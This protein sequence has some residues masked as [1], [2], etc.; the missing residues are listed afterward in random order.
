MVLRPMSSSSL[1]RVGPAT[2][3]SRIASAQ[4]AIATVLMFLSVLLL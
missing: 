2:L 4:H 3:V 1:P